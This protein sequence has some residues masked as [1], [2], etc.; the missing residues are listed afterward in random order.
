MFIKAKDIEYSY[1]RYKED[2]EVE[3]SIKALNKVDINVQEGDF[4]CVLGH[5]GSGKSTFAK[6]LNTL[7]Q[8]EAGMLYVDGMDVTDDANIYNI[9]RHAGMV[10]QNPDNQLVANIV[11][12]DIAFGPENLGIPS[13]Q[14]RLIV[15]ESISS[16]DME[17]YKRHSPNKL[18]GGQKQ[19][20]AIAGVLAMHP[21]CIIFDEPTAMLDPVGRKEIMAI[22]KKLHKEGITIILITH[23][24]EEAVASDYIY[25][26]EKGK[27]AIEGKPKEIFEQVDTLNKLQLDVPH[28]V[29]I[30]KILKE[31][32]IDIATNILTIDEMVEKLWE[33]Q[34]KM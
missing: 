2:G 9:R 11:E 12:E 24:M 27:I 14:I 22:M 8:P 10:F 33:L 4:I 28:T 13:E 32:G 3:A 25:V 20:I 29:Q 26:M 7:L 6:L 30:A 23:F 34:S 1:H 21:K 5:N 16:V 18:S 15:D 17:E 31:N 19:R